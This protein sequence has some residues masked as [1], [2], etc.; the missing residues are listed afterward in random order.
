MLACGSDPVVD[1][2]RTAVVGTARSGLVLDAGPS[3]RT[4]LSTYAT[5]RHTIVIL[6]KR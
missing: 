3:A 4:D 2:V 6:R 5:V 1:A